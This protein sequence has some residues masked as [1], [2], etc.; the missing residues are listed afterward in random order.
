M[1]AG[2]SRARG[3]TRS[4][5]AGRCGGC[6]VAQSAPVA[7]DRIPVMHPGGAD[8]GAVGRGRLRVVD[9]VGSAAR[10]GAATSRATIA[11]GRNSHGSSDTLASVMLRS[12]VCFTF[13]PIT[14]TMTP[15]A[16][17]HPAR[18]ARRPV[19]STQSDERL[20]DLVRAGSD[21]AFEAIVERY[22][23]ALM[24]YVSRLLPPERAEDV[25]QQSFLKAYE[26]MHRNAARAE[27]EAV[28][29]PDRAQR[30]AER[31]ARPGRHALGAER[32]DRRRRAAGPGVRADGRPARA[33]GGRPGASGAPARARS[34]CARWRGGATRRSRPPS[35]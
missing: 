18:L 7:L 32:H 14:R 9:R 10:P 19:L 34:C 13:E 20:V 35:V 29:V 12:L 17:F 6:Q 5:S 22:R 2:S 24:R 25:V 26:A 31:A 15:R 3:R 8:R 4:R 21:P 16:L 28:A 30:R 27:P 1:H 23:R 33:R 11:A